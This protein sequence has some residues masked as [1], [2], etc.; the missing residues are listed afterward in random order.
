MQN[1]IE[2]LQIKSLQHIFLTET[3]FQTVKYHI[4]CKFNYGITKLKIFT[5]GR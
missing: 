2:G 1:A 5:L 3:I 4:T